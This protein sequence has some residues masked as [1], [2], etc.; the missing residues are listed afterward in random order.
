MITL[1]IDGALFSSLGFLYLALAGAGIIASI[2]LLIFVLRGRMKEDKKGEKH[3][4][5]NY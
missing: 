2:T 1:T 3:A 4:Y 5:R